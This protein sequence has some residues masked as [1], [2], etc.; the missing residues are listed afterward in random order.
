MK[1]ISW[2]VNGIRAIAGKGFVETV[3]QLDPD[4]LCL[5]EVKAGE[6][7]V[8]GIANGLE[9]YAVFVNPA[10]KKGYSGTALLTR[11]APASVETGP[12]QDPFL[13]E[14]R[15]Q[16][17]D[18]GDFYLVNTYVPNSG[19]GLKRLDYRTSWDAAFLEYLKE[20][21][22]AKP[23]VLCGDLN[24]AHRAIDLKNDQSNY[25]KTAGYTQAE[26]DGMDRLQGAGFIDVFRQRHPDTVAYTYWSYRFK[27]RE[28]N[29]GWRIDYFLCT[30]ELKDRVKETSIHAD[31]LGSDHCPVGL[32]LD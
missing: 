4:V 14:G 29:I 12:Q 26:I 10:E 9:G 21:H 1:L 22:R 31:V 19:Q 15:I 30:P 2:N 5:Q 20:L 6:E 3:R 17:A 16:C 25:N 28:R 27:A 24:V 7:V 11:V 13:P 23:V 8:S 32:V 18:F